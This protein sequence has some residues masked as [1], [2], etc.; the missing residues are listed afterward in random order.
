MPVP[1]PKRRRQ[2]R[3]IVLTGELP[4][5]LNPPSGCAFRTRCFKAQ[6]LCAE[7][8]PPLARQQDGQLAACHFAAPLPP[9]SGG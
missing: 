5:P 2:S 1:D 8:E 9:V 6:A 4:N 3:R 7:V